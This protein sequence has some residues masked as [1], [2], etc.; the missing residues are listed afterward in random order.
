MFKRLWQDEIERLGY[1]FFGYAEQRDL[2]QRA[3]LNGWTGREPSVLGTFTGDK[4]VEEAAKFM[5]A[6]LEG[7]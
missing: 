5:L 6:Y 3:K 7:K 2:I 4:A 1:K